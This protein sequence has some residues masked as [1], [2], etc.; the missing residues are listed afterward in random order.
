MSPHARSRER[1]HRPASW[2]RLGC[3]L[4]GQAPGQEASPPG[5]RDLFGGRRV[6]GQNG[7]GRGRCLWMR[8]R[9]E[10]LP[11]ACH[12][13]LKGMCAVPLPGVQP[14]NYPEKHVH[15]EATVGAHGSVTLDQ[16]PYEPGQRVDVTISPIAAPHADGTPQYPLSETNVKYNGSFEGVAEAD[17]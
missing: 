13:I 15:V 17:W 4:G 8:Y 6:A 2:V 1:S 9:L 12:R 10:V 11:V 3:V 14:M 7:D 16:L 5:D